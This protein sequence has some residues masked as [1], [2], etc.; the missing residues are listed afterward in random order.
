[1]TS[2]SKALT[3]AVLCTISAQTSNTEIP[4]NNT[5]NSNIVHTSFIKI[6]PL[7]LEK[8]IPPSHS[9][10]SSLSIQMM[11]QNAIQRAVINAE[12]LKDHFTIPNNIIEKCNRKSISQIEGAKDQKQI[13][14]Q[15]ENH[16]SCLGAGYRHWQYSA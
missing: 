3:M 2:L 9:P 6:N 14:T 7:E 15:L 5:Q 8:T 4:E 16:V 10:I 13:K 12:Y 1:M 11:R